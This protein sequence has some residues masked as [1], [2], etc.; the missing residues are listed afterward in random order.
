MQIPLVVYGWLDGFASVGDV[1]DTITTLVLLAAGV[2]IYRTFR[3]RYLFF[4]IIGWSAYL[5]YRVS[6]ARAWELGYPPYMVALTY[7]SFLISSALFAAAVFDYLNRKQWFVYL[8]GATVLAI[9]IATVRC[10][11]F[12]SSIALESTVQLLYRLGTF[13]AGLQL[14]IYSRGRRQLS[15]WLMAMMLLLVHIDFDVVKASDHNLLDTLIENLLGLSMLVLV[16]DESRTRTRRLEVVNE[17]INSMASADDE[18]VV[19]LVALQNLKRLMG[20]TSAWF[21]LLSGDYLEMRAHVGLSD[22]F[23]RTRWRIPAGDQV[24]QGVVRAG[25][26]VIL[27][28]RN[29]DGDLRQ[30]LEDE[31][32]DHIVVIPVQGKASIIGILALASA[33][34]RRYKEDELRFLISAARQLGIAIEN[35]QLISKIL[36]SQRQWANTFDALPDPIFVHDEQFRVLKA[37]RAL[38]NKVGMS[39]ETV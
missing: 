6:L 30:S 19:T 7:A 29:S 28:R 16:L 2:L 15:P 24:G 12:P 35:L 27:N 8:T 9:G 32:Y 39:A 1:A 21:R 26:P 4:W 33:H 10:F 18:N 23:L 14:A 36:R 38:L 34:F 37:N 17:V 13:A 3:E 20:A 31:Q 25:H 11:W 22:R 5:L